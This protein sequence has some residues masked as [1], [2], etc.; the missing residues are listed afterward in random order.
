MKHGTFHY[1]RYA[2]NEKWI[3]LKRLRIYNKKIHYAKQNIRA[4]RSLINGNILRLIPLSIIEN[5]IE[6]YKNNLKDYQNHKRINLHNLQAI[7]I[8]I[9]RYTCHY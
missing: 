2:N 4:L 6:Y 3:A 9:S 1:I 8:W 7:N 5:E